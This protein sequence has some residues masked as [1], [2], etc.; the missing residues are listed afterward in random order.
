MPIRGC[1]HC[2][3]R[4]RVPA[5]RLADAGR[6]GACRGEL[7]PLA[8]PLEVD[9]ASFDEVVAG[10]RVPVLVDFWA[11]WC[12]PCQM[13][14]PQLAQ[15]AAELAGRAVVLKVDIEAEPALAARYAVRSIPLFAAFEGG[16]LRRQQLGLIDHRAL[17]RL[18][19]DAG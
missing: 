16:E 12:G 1:P 18:A 9:A 2:G 13:A 6:C 8:A 14:A 19:L 4:N 11:E 15:A 10:A 7:P 5:A 3:A 17:A